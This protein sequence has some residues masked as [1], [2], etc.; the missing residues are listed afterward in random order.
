MVLQLVDLSLT[1][2]DEIVKDMLVQVGSLIF[3]MDF[4]ILDFDADLTILFILGCPFLATG[5]ALLDVAAKQLTMRA[6]D[7]IKVFDV[8]KQ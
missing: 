8:F 1:K 2:P 3:Y 5:H 6:H 4:F 7:N